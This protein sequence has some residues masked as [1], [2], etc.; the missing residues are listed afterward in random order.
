MDAL[1]ERSLLERAERPESPRL[2]ASAERFVAA[3]DRERL[4]VAGGPFGILTRTLPFLQPESSED[5][6][7]WLPL[8][9]VIG[10]SWRW[11][12]PEARP[13][14][15]DLAA[16][17]LA[18]ARAD[19]TD[20]DAAS[21]W[22]VP[23]FGIGA[24]HEGKNRVRYLRDTCGAELMPASLTTLRFPRADRLQLLEAEAGPGRFYALL[25]DG[26][27]LAVLADPSLSLPLLRAYGVHPAPW[28]NRLPSFDDLLGSGEWQSYAHGTPSA[29]DIQAW[30]RRQRAQYDRLPGEPFD[31]I[32][33]SPH[34]PGF[35]RLAWIAVGSGLLGGVLAALS[36]GHLGVLGSA[37]L[38]A[39]S[40]ATGALLALT[41]PL[42]QAPRSAWKR[43]HC[44]PGADGAT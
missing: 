43:G 3:I 17:L 30:Q 39:A 24:M 34:W 15:E 11:T 38:T 1:S 20:P 4:E 7:Q 31:I 41:I 23:D 16:Y 28:P 18:P 22:W 6:A 35:R 9:C 13:G 2:R 32:D 42:I 36:G 27:W 44:G 33:S 21:G 29:I 25:L 14:R 40:V 10:M 26:R 5:L 37:S 12:E 19:R 8:P